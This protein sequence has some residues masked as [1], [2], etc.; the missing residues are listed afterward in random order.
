MSTRS[1]D[2]ADVVLART[3]VQTRSRDKVRRALAAAETVLAERG[4]DSLSLTAVA[5]QA[6]LSVG[7]VYPYLPDREAIV[8]A[9][10]SRYHA[11]LEAL[12]EDIVAESVT[13][14][15]EDPV[16][17]ALDAFAGLYRDQEGIR[18]LREGRA[19]PTGEARAHK[20]RMAQ[21][22]GE[23]LV[24]RGVLMQGESTGAVARTMFLTADALMHEAFRS[25]RDGD[26]VLIEQLKEM[27]RA[28]LR[29]L[30][31]S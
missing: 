27:L 16:G 29:Q 15:S 10:S 21:R 8:R 1:D 12:M 14:G 28:Y 24:A 3:P 2:L 19:E 26:P 7:A 25:Q 22:V 13:V 20:E 17:E 18:S 6:G 30:T 31:R 5:R 9:L 11:R 23:L 4:P